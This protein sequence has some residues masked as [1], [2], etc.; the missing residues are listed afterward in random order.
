MLTIV[1]LITMKG[2]ADKFPDLLEAISNGA[3]PLR[4]Q[5]WLHIGIMPIGYLRIGKSNLWV[6]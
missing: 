4:Y 2:T 3:F 6:G 5:C 1:A